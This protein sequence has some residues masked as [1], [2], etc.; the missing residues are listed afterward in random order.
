MVA[1]SLECVSICHSRP[2]PCK[3]AHRLVH[4]ASCIMPM[5]HAHASCA[6][7]IMHQAHNSCIMHL[8]HLLEWKRSS[9]CTLMKQRDACTCDD[10]LAIQNS[11]YIIFITS[12]LSFKSVLPQ[13]PPLPSPPLSAPFLW[14]SA[15]TFC[16]T[17][18][19]ASSILH[20]PSCFCQHLLADVLCINVFSQQSCAAPTAVSRA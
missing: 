20:L 19:W 16:F 2:Y 13:V 8:A 9:H 1:L 18:R 10:G 17:R 4:H 15:R 5:H 14:R 3:A 12:S 7:C 11:I 6:S